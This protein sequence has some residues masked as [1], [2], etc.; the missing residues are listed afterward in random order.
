MEYSYWGNPYIFPLYLYVTFL[1]TLIMTIS[2]LWKKKSPDNIP[3][4]GI[5]YEDLIH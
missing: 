1:V 4:A 3:I 5:H 2:A